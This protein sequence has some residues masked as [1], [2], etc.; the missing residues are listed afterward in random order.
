[1]IK[2]LEL[3]YKFL[4]KENL[5]GF[6]EN[7]KISL[8]DWFLFADDDTF[9]HM[10]NLRIF[11]QDKNSKEH[12]QYGH[13]FQSNDDYLSESAG[14]VLSR[15]AYK[16]LIKNISSSD[17]KLCKNKGTDH[18]LDLLSCLRK[19]NITI[20]DSRDEYGYEKF[21]PDSF[22]HH[23]NRSVDRKRNFCSKKWVSFHEKNQFLFDIM[24]EFVDASL[25]DI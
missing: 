25:N 24:I 2:D 5:I 15:K 18:Y 19:L 21:H 3:K 6:L 23:L 1:L 12:I 7:N 9:I 4:T 13:R 22:E 8:F 14:F 17:A 10:N 11:L 20:G 16:S